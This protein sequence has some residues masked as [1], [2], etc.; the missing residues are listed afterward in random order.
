MLQVEKRLDQQSRADEQHRR[1]R[2]LGGGK[3][4]PHP[5]ARG[6]GSAT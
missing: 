3:A 5:R 1:Q 2:E 6:A 4:G